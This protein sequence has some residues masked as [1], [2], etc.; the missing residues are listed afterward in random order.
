MKNSKVKL[1]TY[2]IGV[3]IIG[4]P[5]YVIHKLFEGVVNKFMK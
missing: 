2:Q 3:N 1:V 5:I 4:Q